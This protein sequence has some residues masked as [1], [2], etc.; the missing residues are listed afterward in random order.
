MKTFFS[1]LM[2]ILTSVSTCCQINGDYIRKS[3]ML[4]I[5]E[6][7]TSNKT[8]K[9]GDRYYTAKQKF[10]ADETIHWSNANEYLQVNNTRTGL[11]YNLPA[12]V[13][14]NLGPNTTAYIV[15]HKTTGKS[16]NSQLSLMKNVFEET[17]YMINNE[18]RI[19]SV[20]PMTKT[21][22]FVAKPI[23][24][25]NE[26]PLQYDDETN[27]IYISKSY[28]AK[29]KV[30]INENNNRIRFHVEYYE[31]GKTFPIT[32]NFI[33]EYVPTIK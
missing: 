31:N 5:E 12:K 3:D 10:R 25:N 23:P 19:H 9:I 21:K 27:E 2:L 6:L 16:A 11:S 15:L 4:R 1:L 28:L 24:G 32:D 33:I 20:I 29:N 7:G 13:F 8:I 18:L 17:Y 22:Y 26:F 30:Y 14:L